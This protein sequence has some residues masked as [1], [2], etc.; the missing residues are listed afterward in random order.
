MV[1]VHGF[2]IRAAWRDQDAEVAAAN[3]GIEVA[4]EGLVGFLELA[5]RLIGRGRYFGGAAAP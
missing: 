2:E 4:R 1:A 3:D 5:D